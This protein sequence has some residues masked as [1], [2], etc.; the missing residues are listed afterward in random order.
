MKITAFDIDGTEYAPD[1]IYRLTMTES[2]D[3][4]CSS[5]S[6]YFKSDKRVG[7][8][9]SVRAYENGENIFSG[10]CDCQKISREG[11]GY[12]VY[13]YAR[14]SACLLVDSRS[15]PFTFSCPS[16]RQLWAQYA[17]DKGFKYGLGDISCNEKY[18]VSSSVS[19][20]GAINNFVSAQTGSGIYVSPHGEILLLSESIDVKQLEKYSIISEQTIINRSEPISLISFK[21]EQDTSYNAHIMSMLARE[22]GI[23]STRFCNLSSLPQ[24]Q[25]ENT[26][27]QQLRSSFDSY[28]LL[29]VTVA[30]SVSERLYQRFSYG[31]DKEEYILTEK[32]YSVGGNGEQTRLTLKKRIDA[33][34]VMYVD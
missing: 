24:W 22:K 33:G 28:M 18:E 6:F 15:Q 31:G 26:V 13:I 30:G 20:Y 29:E 2:A 16:A 32:K 17:R 11:S 4:A 27:L 8:L 10:F 25:R 12:S 5:L 9:V 14:S 23:T 3:A 19:C 1:D 7:E 21:R 34:E